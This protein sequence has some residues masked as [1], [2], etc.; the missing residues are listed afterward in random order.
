MNKETQKKLIEVAQAMGAD[1]YA[2]LDP[3]DCGREECSNCPVRSHVKKAVTDD[4]EKFEAFKKE[5]V[6]KYR[7]IFDQADEFNRQIDELEEKKEELEKQIDAINLDALKLFDPKHP[8][9]LESLP[10]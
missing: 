1:D 9:V 5:I 6:P 4:P 3:H 8:L 7:A 10:N 2:F